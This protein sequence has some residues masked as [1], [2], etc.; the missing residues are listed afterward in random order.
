MTSLS[1]GIHAVRS[2]DPDATELRRTGPAAGLTDVAALAD[3]ALGG[4]L[5]ATLG[6]GRTLPTI[7]LTLE[8]DEGRVAQATAVRAWAES[9]HDDLGRAHGVILAGQDQIGHCAAT[10]AVPAQRN[11]LEP[12]PWE[13][14]T[15]D[16]LVNPAAARSA[17]AMMMD[18]S[19]V[20]GDATT[21]RPEATMLNRSGSVQGSALFGLAA[22]FRRPAL[23]MI[24]GHLQFFRPAAV[25]APL[26]CKP[27]VL[28]QTR[29]LVFVQCLLRQ[30]HSSVAAGGFVFIKS[31]V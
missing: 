29:R 12:L 23:R 27:V 14:S 5:R 6:A 26:S 31:E 25:G 10:F 22:R 20:A 18:A 9:V 30:R 4:A 17:E 19:S 2:V 13:T 8:L 28:S 15:G 7:S 11:D 21:L 1:A 16:P 24:S 3:F